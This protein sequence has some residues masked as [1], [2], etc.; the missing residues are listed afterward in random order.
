[1]SENFLARFF[2]SIIIYIIF[3][4]VIKNGTDSKTLQYKALERETK[5]YSHHLMKIFYPFW[6][7][8]LFQFYLKYLSIIQTLSKKNKVINRWSYLQYY[9]PILIIIK[10][11]TMIGI[12]IGSYFEILVFNF[13]SFFFVLLILFFNYKY[14]RSEELE[15]IFEADKISSS[16]KRLLLFSPIIIVLG[17]NGLIIHSIL[18]FL[19]SKDE[20]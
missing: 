19:F 4:Y 11:I 16:N 15:K 18:S 5:I 1:M 8:N 9:V 7:T 10:I 20:D 12:I 17:I 6:M 13:A 14:G 3:L 2:L